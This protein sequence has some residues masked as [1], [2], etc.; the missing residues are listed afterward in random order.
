M[1]DT[2]LSICTNFASFNNN[3]DFS[4]KYKYRRGLGNNLRAQLGNLVFNFFYP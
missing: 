3:F 4:S 2:F 1:K